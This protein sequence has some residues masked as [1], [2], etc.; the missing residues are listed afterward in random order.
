MDNEVSFMEALEIV[1]R[2]I[3]AW[4]NNNILL[5]I[6]KY[7]T[8][9]LPAS[10]WIGDASP[11]YQDIRL[12]CV[13]ETSMVNLQ[14]NQNQLTTWKN[15]GLAFTTYSSNGNVRVY[16]IGGLPSEDYAVQATIQ[17]VVEV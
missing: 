5:A 6:P 12:S 10:N 9:V 16:A 3:K 2:S 11:Y 13:T 14:P 4:T 1:T 8:I 15:S 17:E 7:T